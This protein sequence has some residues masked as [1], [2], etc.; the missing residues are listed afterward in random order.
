MVLATLSRVGPRPEPPRPGMTY[1]G[2]KRCRDCGGLVFWWM[3]PAGRY[4]AHD[5]DGRDHRA[6]CRPGGYR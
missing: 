6:N 3:T 1:R 4:E 5:A 2:S